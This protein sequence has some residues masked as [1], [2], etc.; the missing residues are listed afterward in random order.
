MNEDLQDLE[1]AEF[2]TSH[3]ERSATAFKSKHRKQYDAEFAKLTGATSA[4][5]V[6]EI[7]C[8]TGIF[9]RYLE[10]SHYS[11][12]VGIDMD[13]NLSEALNDLKTSEIYLDDVDR[14]LKNQL[15]GRRFDRIVLLDVCEHLQLPVLFSLM[16]RLTSHIKP[17][18]RLLLR[19]PNIESPWGLKMFF[20]TFDHVTPLGPGRM[21]E[22]GMKTGWICEGCY[23]QEPSRFLRRLKERVLNKLLA[24]LLSYHPDIWSANLL[25][26]YRKS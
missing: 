16:E 21:V 15:D 4:M 10:A 20:G 7:G 5:S 25:A 11:E 8:G 23:P 22:L 13:K 18:G 26:V 2:Y 9:L 1:R 24:A 17:D 3:R 19:V 6:L 14:I 12:I